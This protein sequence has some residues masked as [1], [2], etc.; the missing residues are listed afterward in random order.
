MVP[1]QEQGRE[2]SHPAGLQLRPQG[3]GSTAIPTR[4]GELAVKGQEPPKL[5][6]LGLYLPVTYV[7]GPIKIQLLAT[8]GRRTR[9]LEYFSWEKLAFGQQHI[10]LEWNASNAK[11]GSL[12][13]EGHTVCEVPVS[14][15]EAAAPTAAHQGFSETHYLE[16]R[17]KAAGDRMPH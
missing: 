11:A 7:N 9:G 1:I 2:L 5:R 17:Q 6:E 15:S 14:A 10:P 3:W 8:E 12:L 4:A 16:S 13:P